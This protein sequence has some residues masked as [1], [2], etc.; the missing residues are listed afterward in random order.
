[1]EL[2][3]HPK[4][5]RRR[6]KSQK[7]T[8]GPVVAVDVSKDP[9]DA[10]VCGPRPGFALDNPKERLELKAKK[11]PF[12]MQAVDGENANWLLTF[13]TALWKRTT[14]TDKQT[15]LKM[16][17]LR[18]N[19]EHGMAHLFVDRPRLELGRHKTNQFQDGT[20]GYYQ[21]DHI[22]THCFIEKSSD[23]D[24]SDLSF[25]PMRFDNIYENFF[26]LTPSQVQDLK[27]SLEPVVQMLRYKAILNAKGPSRNHALYTQMLYARKGD[28]VLV[29]PMKYAPHHTKYVK[30][31]IRQDERWFVTQICKGEVLSISRDEGKQWVMTVVL[32]SH[33]GHSVHF[34]FLWC[35]K[36]WA[37]QEN[38]NN[39]NPLLVNSVFE[40]ESILGIRHVPGTHTYGVTF[41]SESLYRQ[42]AQFE[43]YTA[44]ILREK[45][46]TFVLLQPLVKIVLD[47]CGG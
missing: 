39:N 1:M 7:P 25:K 18:V 27:A 23:K 16:F 17:Y 46:D 36:E 44:K 11:P 6:L 40:F 13:H 24:G 3:R 15:I 33:T 42:E 41:E 29:Y 30:S 12:D 37:L 43:R 9:K 8:S 45:A 4:K 22:L 26:N 5:K 20:W 2:K 21:P 32:S 35:G 47:F 19:I 10:K 14:Y 28:K 38:D 31:H 34:V